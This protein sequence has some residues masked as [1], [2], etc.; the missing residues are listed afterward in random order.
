MNNLEKTSK[1]P[2]FYKLPVKE[3][4]KIIK[5]FAGLTR[6]ET[7]AIEKNGSLSIFAANNMIENVIGTYELPLGIACNFLINNK[8]YLIPMA[9]EEPSVVAA[10]SNSAKIIRQSGGFFTNSTKPIMIGQI[11]FSGIK[12]ISHSKQIIL[13]NKQKLLDYANEQGILV[14]F[15]GGAKE[16]E[17][18][19]IPTQ[20]FGDLLVVHLFVDCCDA[21][22]ANAVNTICEAVSVKI[23]EFLK[24]GTI[25]F[26]I[27]SN[28]ATERLVRSRATI[29][30][31][32]LKEDTI[33]KILMGY[34]FASNDAYRAATHN[35]G[36]M[37][38]IVAATLACGNDTR[39]VEAGAH[40]W[41]SISGKY[42]PLT[43]YEKD[44]IGN[45]CISI[46]LP[47]ALGI[48][49][50]STKVHPIAQANLK[51]IGAKTARELAEVF[52]SLG[53]AQNFAAL[54]A[55]ATEGI[56]KGHM[57]LHSRNIAI[58][59]GAKNE[60]QIIKIVSQMT[61]EKN[62][63]LKKAKE[64]FEKMQEKGFEPS[65]L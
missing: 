39:A 38:G 18:K 1:L 57:K 35:K 43:K 28:L 11:Q 15:G 22:G 19:I 17:V 62:I 7:D 37:N 50:G 20:H 54:R 33:N 27:I 31:E 25:G 29:K 36:I 14:Q 42:L 65:N 16:I 3:R 56:Q 8:E 24:Q 52:A 64:I 60:E 46:E 13:E 49:G 47:L 12:N 21:M 53:L 32:L 9:T 4:L 45:L 61:E 26:R 2:G 23:K 40:S 59:A 30:K 10:A 58:S 63:S 51:I 55:I 34:E 48:V 44:N 41:A 5:D 6:E